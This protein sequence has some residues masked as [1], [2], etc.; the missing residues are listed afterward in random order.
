MDDHEEMRKY[1]KW[2][3]E[4]LDHTLSRTCCVRDCGP[5]IRHRGSGIET[6]GIRISARLRLSVQLI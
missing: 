3:E 1:W 4:A 5:V 2:K 6:L